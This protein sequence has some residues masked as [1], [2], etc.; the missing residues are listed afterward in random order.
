MSERIK[1]GIVGA[2]GRMGRVIAEG[3]SADGRFQ[4]S[5]L[6]DVKEGQI[7]GVGSVCSNL[8]DFLAQPATHVVDFSIGEAVFAQGPTILSAGKRYLV[9]ATGYPEGTIPKLKEMAEKN[10][11][12]CLIVPN[13]SLGANLMMRFSELAGK[14]FSQIEIVEA[15]H[16]GKL[17]APSGTAMATAKAVAKSLESSHTQAPGE[18]QSP[19]RGLFIA[20]AH[21]HSIRIDGVLA[22]QNV[23]FGAPGETLTITHRTISRE[24]YLAG[25]KLAL[26]KL[27]SFTGLRVGLSE[28]MDELGGAK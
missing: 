3:L 21:I 19:A 5:A 26:M 24:C 10:S 12:S 25:V 7:E 8:R 15:H 20:N 14:F 4:V 27:T 28:V 18:N 23:I 11:T 16:R 17:D 13:F 2:L 9:G 22:E 1:V 6:Y